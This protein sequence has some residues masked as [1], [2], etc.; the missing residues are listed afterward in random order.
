MR[1]PIHHVLV[2][3]GST[4]TPRVLGLASLTFIAGCGGSEAAPQSQSVAEDSVRRDSA[5]AATPRDVSDC[6]P[7]FGAVLSTYTV[8]NLSIRGW[9][10]A[11][12]AVLQVVERQSE[13]G[14]T[15]TAY[16]TRDQIS[17]PRI[18][19]DEQFVTY[20]CKKDGVYDIGIVGVARVEDVPV[21]RIVREAWRVDPAQ[22]KWESLPVE[23]V[24]CDNEAF[25][26]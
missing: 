25:G 5:I 4:V 10:C 13:L 1:K 17:I 12:V 15:E 19:T 20:F 6:E 7:R 23:T 16:Q 2:S 9:Q 18:S 3:V 8:P 11:D 22:L 21:F 26:V 24:E 14:A